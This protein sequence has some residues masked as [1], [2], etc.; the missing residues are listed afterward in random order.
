M[1]VSNRFGI[2]GKPDLRDPVT[3]PAGRGRRLSQTGRS[4]RN[5]VSSAAVT[6][7]LARPCRARISLTAVD[8]ITWPTPLSGRGTLVLLPGAPAAVAARGRRGDSGA[9]IEPPTRPLAATAVVDHAR[10]GRRR[11]G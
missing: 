9:P 11:Y 2:S 7:A 6:A 10:A 3:R 4:C 8:G 5:A 1:F